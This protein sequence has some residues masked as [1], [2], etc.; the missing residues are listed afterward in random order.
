MIF[1][2]GKI[3]R[4]E[5]P[6]VRFAFIT[7]SHYAPHI[8]PVPGDRRRY[9]DA[10]VKMRRFA[11]H[12]NRLHAAFAVEG[13]DFKDLG[14]TR[15]E[16]FSYLDSM[17]GAFSIFRGP[18]FHVLGNHDHDNL[19]KEEFL[20]RI[21]NAGQTSARAFYAFDMNG[22]RFIVLDSC[23]RPDGAPYCR[24]DFN[25]RS[26]FLPPEQ[27][28]F[29]REALAS[30]PGPCIPI[31]H[32]QLD[33]EDDTRVANADEVRRVI[34]GSGKVRCV[35]QGHLH[36]GSWRELGGIAYFTSPAS[37]F[38]DAGVSEAHS[39]IEVFASGA[40]RIRLFRWKDIFRSASAV[41]IL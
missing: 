18:R 19:S 36:E 20:S 29:L 28:A 13:G 40:V 3:G 17:E 33:A 12:A 23:Y 9:G 31:L 37:V 2:A 6:L 38:D 34:E 26:T 4:N 41:A 25:W 30:A 21:S 35:V 22:V 32:H 24:G 27:V 11:L 14:R 39:L 1:T 5:R 7:D 15:E 8:A 16:S 10:L